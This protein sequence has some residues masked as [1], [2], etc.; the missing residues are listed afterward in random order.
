MY[1]LLNLYWE[2][3]I[4]AYILNVF[5][6]EKAQGNPAAVVKLNT[7]LPESELKILSKNLN[8]PVTSFIVSTE[9]GYDIRWFAGVIEINLCGHGSLAAAAAIFEMIPEH[10]LDIQLISKYGTVIVNKYAK[11]FAMTM[12]SWKPVRTHK[13]DKYSKLLGLEPIDVFG[14]RDLV[15]VLD[16]E[17]S[18]L[19]F[20]PDFS[21]IKNIVTITP[22]L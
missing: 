10:K 20:K 7:W 14:T 16:N 6:G 11:G 2:Q 17:D 21:V 19:D 5:T 15:L 13:L 3:V 1:K 18:V 4:D 12:P 8:Q 9:Q 22:L